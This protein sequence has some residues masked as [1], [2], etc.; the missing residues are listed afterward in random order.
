MKILFNLVNCGLGNNGG[1]YNIIKSANTLV[2]LGH[3]VTIVDGGKNKNTWVELKAEHV[4]NKYPKSD[5]VI[6]TGMKTLG[7]L[8]SFKSRLF[9]HWLRAFETWVEP[10]KTIIYNLEHSPTFKMVNSIGLQNKLKKYGIHSALI[11]AGN[12]F[13]EIYPLNIRKDNENIVI[14]GLYSQ[15]EKRSGKRTEWIFKTV[16]YLK[17]RNYDVKLYMFGVDG[18]PQYKVDKYLYDPSI[19]EKNKLYNEIDIWLSPSCNEGLH[20]CPQEAMLTEAFVVGNNSKLSGTQDYLNNK[21][22]IV[23]ENDLGYFIGSVEASI[24]NPK[25]RNEISKNG[26]Q[27][28]L[29]LGSREDN[30]KNLISLLEDLLNDRYYNDSNPKT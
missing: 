19:D 9:V 30:M 11:R 27:K 10:E 8:Y 5:V 18:H 23:S 24:K 28:I 17:S 26:R 21:T 1:S 13:D 2:D 14:G 7:N 6:C 12:S 29:S 16:D 3:D 25:L 22:G 4:V 15:G 20:V